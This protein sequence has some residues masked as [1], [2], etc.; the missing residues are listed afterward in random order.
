MP[1]CLFQVCQ[2]T[3]ELT[4]CVLCCFWTIKTNKKNNKKNQTFSIL[5]ARWRCFTWIV[6]TP[7]WRVIENKFQKYWGDGWHFTNQ[8]WNSFYIMVMTL[9]Y[10]IVD[11]ET[12]FN[13]PSLRHFNVK[14][15]DRWVIKFDLRVFVAWGGDHLSMMT[16]SNGNIFRVTGHLCGEFTGPRW[17][18][19]TKASDAELWC[20]FVWINGWVNT[21]EADNLRHYRAHYDVTVMHTS[22]A[23]LIAAMIDSIRVSSYV[24]SS[25]IGRCPVQSASL[26]TE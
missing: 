7:S 3:H 9:I 18:P 19:R 21:R 6:W 14:V 8:I 20:F 13:Y 26:H 2:C 23:P 17:I 12:N 1:Q 10:I 24:H 11:P 16:S 15:S 22:D 25:H 5:L 4:V